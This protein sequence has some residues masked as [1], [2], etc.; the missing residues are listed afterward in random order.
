MN[1]LFILRCDANKKA[2]GDLIQAEQYK[3]VLEMKINNAAI[4]FYH[5]LSSQQINSKIWDI[6]QVFNISRL[7]ENIFYL[8]HVRYKKLIFT[9]ILQPGFKFDKLLKFKTVVKL[10]FFKKRFIPLS[11]EV[12]FLKKIDAIVFLS[13]FERQAFYLLFPF[14]SS[15][16]NV[17]YCNGVNS[18]GIDDFPYCN[19]RLFDYIIVGRIEPKKRVIEAINIVK[20]NNKGSTIICI[21]GLNW[22]NPFYCIMFLYK[23][24]SGKAIYCGGQSSKVVFFLMK[25]SRILLNF[26]E[27]EVSPLVDLEALKC[28]C[29]VIS[30]KYSY[31]HLDD[32]NGFVRIDVK[33]ETE[34]INA[35]NQMQL[36]ACSNFKHDKVKSWLDNSVQ[37]IS[38][39]SYFLSE[40]S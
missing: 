11:D 10:F 13:T 32:F 6:V 4:F 15:V 25:N 40:T 3:K 2:G 22:Y 1:I 31:S 23:I 12:E 14:L 28:G 24:I 16:T 5:E 20:K 17:V 37:Y 39:I 29:S 27:L 19:D 26:S 9:P 34:C 35:I 38:L 36:D 21:G 8:K 18:D 30:T 33:N 7:Y